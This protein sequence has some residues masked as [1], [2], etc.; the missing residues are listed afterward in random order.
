M[1]TTVPTRFAQFSTVV[2]LGHEQQHTTRW[3]IST[4]VQR[5]IESSE[6]H[7]SSRWKSAVVTTNPFHQFRAYRTFQCAAKQT[8]PPQQRPE[9]SGPCPR[10]WLSAM[11][12]LQ[13]M[14]H[15]T[16]VA[17]AACHACVQHWK[18]GWHTGFCA[19]SC[20]WL[21]YL[22]RQCCCLRMSGRCTRCGFSMTSGVSL[23]QLRGTGCWD[24]FADSKPDFI[25]ICLWSWAGNLD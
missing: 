12:L 8:L 10:C 19:C 21:G 14:P 11:C 6:K 23:Q 1:S 17:A 7:S 20:G 9:A 15:L 24:I 16:A 13:K 18:S 2:I 22:G 5:T 25:D 4:D 3:S